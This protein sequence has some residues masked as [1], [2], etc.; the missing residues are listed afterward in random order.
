MFSDEFVYKMQKCLPPVQMREAGIAEQGAQNS[1]FCSVRV[2]DE[3]AQRSVHKGTTFY[4][5]E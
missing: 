2:G 5:N 3:Q 4:L 1:P